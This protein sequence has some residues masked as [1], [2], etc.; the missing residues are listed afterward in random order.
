MCY[1]YFLNSGI[2]QIAMRMAALYYVVSL[3]AIS[4]QEAD[5]YVRIQNV[6]ILTI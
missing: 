5:L 3:F 4:G 6:I 2:Y 1:F